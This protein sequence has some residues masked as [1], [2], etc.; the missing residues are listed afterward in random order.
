MPQCAQSR[1]HFVVGQGAQVANVMQ[2]SGDNDFFITA[3]FFGDLRA[4]ASVFELADGLSEVVLV[5]PVMQQRE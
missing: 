2:Q 3:V 1:H 4:L 5:S